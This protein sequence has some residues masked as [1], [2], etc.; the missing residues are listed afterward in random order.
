MSI[1]VMVYGFFKTA[2]NMLTNSTEESFEENIK[3][4]FDTFV[5]IGLQILI[6]ADIIETIIAPD[7]QTIST[8]LIVVIIRTIMSWELN[9]E[10]K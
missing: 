8:V 7:L 5:L 3:K 6:V 9:R 1:V 10:K 2:K 4:N